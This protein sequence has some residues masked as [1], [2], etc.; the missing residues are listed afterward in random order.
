MGERESDIKSV[1]IL[2][3]II[4]WTPNGIEYGSD[5][6]H[7]EII[8]KQIGILANSESLV[9]PES[10][11]KHLGRILEMRRNWDQ[12]KHPLSEE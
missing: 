3:R 9:T 7:A 11:V 5:Q 1:R 8:V 2:N 6:R 12:G 10:V 4:S